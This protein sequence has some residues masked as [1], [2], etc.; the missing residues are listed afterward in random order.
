LE[1]RTG[2]Q[3]TLLDWHVPWWVSPILFGVLLAGWVVSFY[4]TLLYGISFTYDQVRTRWRGPRAHTRAERACV[5]A[6]ANAWL[7]S[8]AISVAT[9]FVVLQS[10][11]ALMSSI[12]STIFTVAA[13]GTAVGAVAASAE[14]MAMS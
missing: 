12:A 1:R 11:S 9:S 8:F 14:L 4:F 2:W 10:V 7:A 3:R 6:Q 13:V 5:A